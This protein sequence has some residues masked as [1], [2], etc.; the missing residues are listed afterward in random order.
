MS[1]KRKFLGISFI[2]AIMLL[3][4]GAIGLSNPNTSADQ[5]NVTVKVEV[6]HSTPFY[7][8]INPMDNGGPMVVKSPTYPIAVDHTNV[9]RLEYYDCFGASI[10]N[11]PDGVT[12]FATVDY[13]NPDDMTGTTTRDVSLA[14]NEG[15][16]RI[17]VKAYQGGTPVDLGQA[18]SVFYDPNADPQFRIEEVANQPYY[19]GSGPI[20]V[21]TGDVDITIS[22][23]DVRQIEIWDGDTKV[24]TCDT[25]DPINGLLTCPF[26]ISETADPDHIITIKA[27]DTEDNYLP[28]QTITIRFGDLDIPDTGGSDEPNTG[29]FKIGGMTVGKED[30]FVSISVLVIA[31][32]SFGLYI[33]CRRK[34]QKQS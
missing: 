24:A 3:V 19:G 33:A 9:S 18:V 28:S 26:K 34:D 7:Q 22:Y 30:V 29:V 11:C 21:T 13:T 12:P 17:F 20:E 16:H 6:K 31:L 1:V 4:T 10:A 27:I 25:V 23:V 2:S 5:S 14:P 32:V 8:I 15:E